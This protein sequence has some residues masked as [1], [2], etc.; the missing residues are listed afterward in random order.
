MLALRSAAGYGSFQGPLQA[1]VSSA[2]AASRARETYDMGRQ[3]TLLRAAGKG[4]T[5]PRNGALS[6]GLPGARVRRRPGFS[7]ARFQF[8]LKRINSKSSSW[9]TSG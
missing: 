2:S 4:R 8:S 1:A 3:C 7:S 9:C 5:A 6:D